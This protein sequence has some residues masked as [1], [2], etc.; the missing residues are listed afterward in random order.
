M[1]AFSQQL[2]P[3]QMNSGVHQSAAVLQQQAQVQAQVAQAAQAAAVAAAAASVHTPQM[4]HQAGLQTNLQGG[5]QASMPSPQVAALASSVIREVWRSN[6][7]QEMQ[8]VREMCERF[9]YVSVD[10]EFPGIV[11]RPMGSFKTTF[12]YH[13][14]TLRCNVDLLHVVQLA[15]TFSDQNG[16]FPEGLPSTFQFNFK[17]NLGEEMYS[18]ESI[19]LMTKSG[20]DFKKHE[21]FGIDPFEFA[22]LFITSGIVLDKQMKW[23]TFHSAYDLG[24]LISMMTNTALPSEEEQYL[25]LVHTFFPNFYDVKLM[26]RYSQ[27]K[28]IKG[29]LQELADELRISRIGPSHHAGSESLLTQQCFFQLQKFTQ[30]VAEE[31]YM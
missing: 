21:E 2:P 19:D 27:I 24:Y 6:F 22:E 23:M 20:I 4:P 8:L 7:E 17:F 15:I 11:A 30:D 18:A 25:S 1:G 13:Y 16:H 28:N 26:L 29:S 9:R 5:L 14:Q 31:N 12:D 3:P 10:A